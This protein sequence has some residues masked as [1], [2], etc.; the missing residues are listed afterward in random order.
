[1]PSQG[2]Y[3]DAPV[4]PAIDSLGAA[5]GGG[6]LAT[7]L[8]EGEHDHLAVPTRSRSL[9]ARDSYG[10]DVPLGIAASAPG[11]M[12]PGSKSPSLVPSHTSQNSLISNYGNPYQ[13]TSTLHYQG[14]DS[15]VDPE[16]INMD[17]IA[18]DEDDGFPSSPQRR[19]AFSLPNKS[20][21]DHDS[22]PLP[23]AAG[24]AVGS[25]MMGT[26]GGIF[27]R[28]RGGTR[29]GLSY[30]LVPGMAEKQRGPVPPQ[31]DGKRAN[32]AGRFRALLV[33]FVILGGIIA[34][35]VI[36]IS[37]H[38]KKSPAPAEAEDVGEFD[39]DSPQIKALMNN[40]N[41]HKVFPG[42]DY[43]PWG[44]QYPLCLQYPPI[45]NNVTQDVAV[46]SQLTDT[47][48]L[49]GTDCNQTEMVLYAIDKLELTE[50]KVWLGVWIDTDTPTSER[51]LTQMY[52]IIDETPDKSIFSGAIIGNEVLFRASPD[53]APAETGLIDY[54]NSVRANFTE[55]NLTLPVAT[56][57][58]GD[59]WNKQL[60]E[61]VD[62]V[63]SNVHPFF[64]GVPVDQAASWAWTFW[65]GHDVSLSQ[66][67]KK[68]QV[69][70]EIGWPSGGGT[71][72][73]V[74]A[75]CA[76]GQSG[77][78]A[79]IDKMNQFMAE[80]VCQALKNGTKYFW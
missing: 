18:D 1:M 64:G 70:S 65:E 30:G 78:V 49:Y 8:A 59:N 80:W 72:C 63:M 33:V 34:G 15:R 55:R 26:I 43:T 2:Q 71:D 50:M 54:I 23:S 41:L 44:V 76:S 14:Y 42:M 4:I 77:A 66:D 17:E 79:G 48:R 46:L 5:A 73:G 32:W 67:T 57:D 27:K 62:I 52:K 13:G 40:P 11:Q 7:S 75:T 36:G 24:A 35:I 47:I 31:S 21:N 39:L 6:E 45:Q 29:P 53:I 9:S 12:T 38:F 60:V 10:S 37:G 28:D 16:N 20:S 61:A 58:L 69:I 51:Q 25:K 3:T 68:T 56:S 74:N 19:S 22:S